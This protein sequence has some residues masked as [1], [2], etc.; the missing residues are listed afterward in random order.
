MF[1]DV[2]NVETTFRD[3]DL[4]QLQ[5]Q[6][7][8][9][10]VG[11]GIVSFIHFKWGYLRPLLL[12]SVLGVKSFIGTPLAQVYLLGKKTEGELARPW[13]KAGGAG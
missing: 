13:A 2:E 9:M 11:L 8:Q 10:I 6:I 4:S 1:R 7:M 12:Q 3:H 5:S